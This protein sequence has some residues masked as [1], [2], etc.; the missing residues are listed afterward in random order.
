MS[1]IDLQY[2]QQK[3]HAT[4]LQNFADNLTLILTTSTILLVWP[5]LSVKKTL[6][7][8]DFFESFERIGLPRFRLQFCHIV[9]RS[10]VRLS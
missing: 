2:G 10:A 6:E 7:W 3:N 8:W 5:R 1:Q 9:R 4:L